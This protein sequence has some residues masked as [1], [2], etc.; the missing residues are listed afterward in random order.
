[1]CAGFCDRQFDEIGAIVV[2][3]LE[4]RMPAQSLGSRHP[5]VNAMIS[6]PG[7]FA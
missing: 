5:A 6:I 3:D 4:P 7:R 1:M 2:V